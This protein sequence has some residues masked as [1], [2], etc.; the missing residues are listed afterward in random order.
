MDTVVLDSVFWRDPSDFQ[1]GDRGG[2]G[3]ADSRPG[4]GELGRHLVGQFAVQRA[5]GGV[6]RPEAVRVVQNHLAVDA[7]LGLEVFDRFVS[8]VHVTYEGGA[9]SSTITTDAGSV[10]DGPVM[11][12]AF[13]LVNYSALTP[14]AQ[15]E[16]PST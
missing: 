16:A 9:P 15:S 7:C 4:S 13:G 8:S 12:F 2:G 6:P 5:S 10:A 1:P 3:H 14:S 11:G